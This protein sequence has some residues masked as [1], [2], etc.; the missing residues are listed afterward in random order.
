[1]HFTYC[2]HCGTKLIHKEIGD[3]GELPFCTTCSQPFW[4]MFTTSIICAVINEY[5]EIA[6]IRQAY[7]SQ[8]NYVCVAGIMQLGET[9]EETAKREV[10]EEIGQDVERLTYIQSYFYEQKSMLMLG[11]RADVK[12]SDFILSGEV[13]SAAWFTP[14]EALARLREG[15][16]AWRLVRESSSPIPQRSL[17]T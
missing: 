7:V 8:T 16:I 5:G 10:R 3:E 2:P 1:M 15:S 11:Y 17:T 12:K 6:L 13:D 4:D 14:E 9:A